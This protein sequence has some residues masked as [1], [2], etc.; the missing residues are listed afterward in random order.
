MSLLKK[1]KKVL[2]SIIAKEEKSPVHADCA[3]CGRHV[4]LPYHCQY[5]NQYYCSEHRLP[6]NHDCRNIGAWKNRKPLSGPAT[7]YR[8]GSIHVRK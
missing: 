4:Y 1:I 2:S 7:D 6:F 5:C 8:G 3:F